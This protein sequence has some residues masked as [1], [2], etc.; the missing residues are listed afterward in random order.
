MPAGQPPPPAA[1]SP[2]PPPA[3]PDTSGRPAPP[4]VGFIAPAPTVPKA[5]TWPGVGLSPERGWEYH[6]ARLPESGPARPPA[7]RAP[8]RARRFPRRRL[9]LRG[10]HRD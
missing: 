7:V 8:P 10:H 6:A 3:P 9:V 5:A 1:S 4:S 2:L